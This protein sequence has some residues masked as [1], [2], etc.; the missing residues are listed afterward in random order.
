MHTA[1]R[2]DKLQNMTG[3]TVHDFWNKHWSASTKSTVRFLL[4]VLLILTVEIVTLTI[5]TS[6]LI[7][8]FTGDTELFR[9]GPV[10]FL[11]GFVQDLGTF[12][13]RQGTLFGLW[14]CTVLW[15]CHTSY[16]LDGFNYLVETT[17]SMSKNPHINHFK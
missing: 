10:Q 12:L 3:S 15:K 11:T 2:N 7:R 4:L 17:F 6:T 9:Y 5:Q 1:N 8:H 16:F 13:G 14:L